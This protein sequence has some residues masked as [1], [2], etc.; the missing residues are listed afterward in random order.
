MVSKFEKVVETLRIPLRAGQLLSSLTILGLTGYVAHWYN[1]DTLTSAPHE[2]NFLIFAALFSIL[3][4]LYV[5]VLP[6]V[7]RPTATNFFFRPVVFLGLEA[8]NFWFWFGGAVALAAFLGKLLFCNGSVCAS[9]QAAD[10]F[11]FFHLILWG[12]TCASTALAV[13]KRAPAGR[14]GAPMKEVV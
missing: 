2:I 1:F 6:R 14:A 5:E 7:F 13:F 4:I 11:S 3:S 9:A 10:V 8:V 12:V